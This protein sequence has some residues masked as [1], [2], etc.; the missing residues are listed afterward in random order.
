MSARCEPPEELRGVDGWHWVRWHAYAPGD[1]F[2][3]YW[4]A[5]NGLNGAW[6]IDSAHINRD[7][8]R[9]YLYIGSVATPDTVRALVEALDGLMAGSVWKDAHTFMDGTPISAGW[10]TIR[11]PTEEAL[12][13]ARAALA[14]AKAEGL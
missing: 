12:T 6:D 14:R 11:M 1:E 9:K 5:D 8:G 10:Q 13:E 3:A 7:G 4:Q 2:I